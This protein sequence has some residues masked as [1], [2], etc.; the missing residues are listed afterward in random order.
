VGSIRPLKNKSY[1]DE[2]SKP[3]QTWGEGKNIVFFQKPNKSGSDIRKKQS[4]PKPMEQNAKKTCKRDD[5]FIFYSI[6]SLL[7]P[8]KSSGF[9]EKPLSLRKI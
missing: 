2:N 7:F 5:F 9:E 6:R 3:H 8:N 4:T 1:S